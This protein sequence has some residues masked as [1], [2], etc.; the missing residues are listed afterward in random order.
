M[1]S[2]TIS[3]AVVNIE[4]VGVPIPEEKQLSVPAVYLVTACTLMASAG[5]FGLVF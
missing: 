3:C 1:G 2:S 5:V 4:H